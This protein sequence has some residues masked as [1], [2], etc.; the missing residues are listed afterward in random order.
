MVENCILEIFAAF[1]RLT[2]H[3]IT[4]KTLFASVLLLLCTG[5][6]QARLQRL[7]ILP[8][9]TT[10][11]PAGGTL[12]SVCI[13]YER[14]EPGYDSV[15]RS[16]PV[17]NQLYDVG[18]ISATVN[19]RAYPGGLKALA[20]GPQPLLILQATSPTQVRVRLNSRH[21][22]AATV[23]NIR[24]NAAAPGWI[25]TIE[26]DTD[27]RM[28]KIVLD[29]Y[30]PYMSQFEFWRRS[31]SLD[32]LA[33]NNL[34]HFS[35]G[36]Q[37]DSQTHVLM[38]RLYGLYVLDVFNGPTIKA[39]LQNKLIAIDPQG[40]LGSWSADFMN[41][42]V[43]Y[44]WAMEHALVNIRCNDTAALL[45]NQ[46]LIVP[47][48]KLLRDTMI[49]GERYIL[50]QSW[51]DTPFINTFTPAQG[52]SYYITDSV[53]FSPDAL[54][55]TL[56]PDM[57]LWYNSINGS[58]LSLSALKYRINAVLGMPPYSDNNLFVEF[59]ARPQDIFRP[60]PDSST[61]VVT[62]TG[63]SSPAY[64]QA[65]HNYL[66]SSYKGPNLLD[67]YPFAAIGLTYDCSPDNPSHIGLS[68]FVIRQARKLYIRRILPTEE[69]FSSTP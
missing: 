56:A 44:H 33:A 27:V 28:A 59:W 39:F 43:S 54:F 57:R 25:G 49:N 4:M 20:E 34:M 65:L 3:L 41:H 60:A 61:S 35:N 68:E 30:G 55:I 2:Q 50:T 37:L 31:K 8:Q 17:Y 32:I 63:K 22:Q 62:L 13:D 1:R 45:N 38:N 16:Y 12:Q 23:K 53:F 69:Y 46:R 40:L 67:E 11:T 18:S 10:I 19:G 36:L 52:L 15:K 7:A 21:P 26:H 58:A 24:L 6:V 66:V 64:L 47:E 5:S 48:N 9:K 51:Q 29:N 42:A 14:E